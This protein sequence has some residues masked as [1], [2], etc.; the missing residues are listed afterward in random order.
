MDHI[1]AVLL[2][3][4]QYDAADRK[5]NFEFAILLND[6]FINYFIRRQATMVSQLIDAF[7]VSRLIFVAMTNI[8]IL[9]LVFF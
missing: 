3:Q 4:L 7:P 6:L 5:T 2:K 1:G 8:D 9:C